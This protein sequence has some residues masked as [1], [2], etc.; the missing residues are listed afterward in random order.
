MH[1]L[2]AN[3]S[4][5]TAVDLMG[6]APILIAHIHKTHLNIIFPHSSR[7][8][9]IFFREVSIQNLFTNSIAQLTAVSQILL[10]VDDVCK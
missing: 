10:T 3:P 8:P 5:N 7:S 4:L 9:V 6:P 2:T 1:F